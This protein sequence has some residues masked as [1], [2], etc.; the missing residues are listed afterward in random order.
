VP[1]DFSSAAF[2]LVAGC[3][4]PGTAVTVDN[5][6]LTPPRTGLLEALSEMGADFKITNV[7]H[8]AGEPVGTITAAKA[9]LRGAQIGGALLNFRLGIFRSAQIPRYTRKE[10][11]IEYCVFSYKW[12]RGNPIC[13]RWLCPSARQ[14]CLLWPMDFG[15]NM[16]AIPEATTSCHAKSS[17]RYRAFNLGS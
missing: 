13:P 6:L 1:G 9:S 12:R 14:F 7:I 3:L 15:S 2:F 17:P 5:V 4:L 16:A 8:S 11:N 10:K